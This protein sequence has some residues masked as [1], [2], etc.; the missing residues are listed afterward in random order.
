[1]TIV[2]LLEKFRRVR[3]QFALVVGEYGEL[4]GVVTLTDVLRSIVGDLDPDRPAH[5]RDLVQRPDGSWLCDGGV[6]LERLQTTLGLQGRLVDDAEESEFHTVGGL[7]MHVLGRVPQAT[8]AFERAG[9]RFEVLD[10]D[11][12]R[13]DKVLL[14]PVPPDPRIH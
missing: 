6:A 14:L 13:I 5:E 3:Q 11:G 1:V 7:V 8:D 2:Q 10:M 4:V 12:N 9:W